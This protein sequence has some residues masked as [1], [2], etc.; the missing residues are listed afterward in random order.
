ML[1]GEAEMAMLNELPVNRRNQIEK[2]NFKGFDR[3][4]GSKKFL[5]Q[6]HKVITEPYY[7]VDKIEQIIRPQ[8]KS[9]YN[10]LIANSEYFQ[11]KIR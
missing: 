7:E 4:G 6:L 10:E 9:L 8:K 3:H 1:K 11:N 5:R 2:A